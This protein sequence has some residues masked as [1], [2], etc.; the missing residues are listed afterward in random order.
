MRYRGEPVTG[1]DPHL[2]I[3]F[4]TFALF[5]WLTVLENVELGLEAQPLSRTQRT[6]RA[7]AAID[8]IGLDGF[9]DAYPKELS[10]GMRQRVGFARALV[11]EPEL[12][13]M[14]EPF[15]A[16]DVL[17]AENLRNELLRLWHEGRI[18][19]KAILM[20]THN[21]EEAALM[22][23]RLVVMGHDPGIVRAILDGVPA[24]QRASKSPEHEA[25]VDIVYEIITQ[26]DEDAA[27]IIASHQR[28]A[29]TPVTR[30]APK[31]KPRIY[32]NLPQVKIG[33][34]N[35]LAERVLR[36]GGQEDL[37]RWDVSCNWN[38]TISCRWFERWSYSASV[39]HPAVIW[40]SAT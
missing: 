12:L 5:P 14:D 23:D 3:I 9:E 2:A 20:V 10:G 36:N 26:P 37:W 27:E 32:Q 6:K 29:E 13:F 38:W 7:L 30:N 28:K 11:V 16:L 31:P 18:P 4:Q 24:D 39:K 33:A 19:T 15:S 35:G 21:I 22:A 25:L 1:P 40:C 34:L 17:T 8:T